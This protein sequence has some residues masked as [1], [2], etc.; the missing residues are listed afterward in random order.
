MLNSLKLVL[1]ALALTVALTQAVWAQDNGPA[2]A[3]TY[4]EVTPSSTEQTVNLLRTQA[5]ASRAAAGNLRFQIM[6]RVG[7]P[8]HFVILDAWESQEARDNNLAAAHTQTFRSSLESLLYSPY[9]ERP[10][11]G[12]LGTSATGDDGQIYAITHVDFIPPALEE[13]L[14]VLE[15][16]VTASR[17]APGAIDI[18]IITQNNRRNH[19]TQFEAW[20]SAEHRIAHVASS[21]ARHF[22]AEVYPRAGALYDERIYR[23]L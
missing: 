23:G 21:Q 7:R 14:A 22:R 4:I 3:V 20:A 13:G 16:F 15:E 6:Q 1:S 19:M 2:F 17:E 10:S 5:A 18:G 11:Y 9:D 12:I 8:Y